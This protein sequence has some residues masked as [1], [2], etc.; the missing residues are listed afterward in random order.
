MKSGQI[1]AASHARS[2]NWGTKCYER[3]LLLKRSFC[4]K[5][6]YPLKLRSKGNLT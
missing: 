2:A 6:V 5:F 4:G 3:N 1:I